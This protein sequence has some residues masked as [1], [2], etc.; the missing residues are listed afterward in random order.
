MEES[1]NMGMRINTDKTEIQ[2]LGVGDKQFQI[3]VKGQQLHQT[4]NFVYLGHRRST[5]KMAQWEI[6]R[7][8]S[9]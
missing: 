2:F 5:Q 3:K 9:G 1:E 6:S 7:E 8:E 4:G